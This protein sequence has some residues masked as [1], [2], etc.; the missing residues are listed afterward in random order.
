M[1]D[2]LGHSNFCPSVVVE[3]LELFISLSRRQREATEGSLEKKAGNRGQFPRTD[4]GPVHGIQASTN[5]ART[6]LVWGFVLFLK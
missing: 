1:M 6:P 5:A 2:T 4:V 3:A